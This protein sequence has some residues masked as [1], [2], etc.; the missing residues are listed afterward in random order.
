MSN[1]TVTHF[2]IV[3]VIENCVHYIPHISFKAPLLH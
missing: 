1:A 2:Y 3:L